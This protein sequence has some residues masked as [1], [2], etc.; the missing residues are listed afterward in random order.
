MKDWRKE[1]RRRLREIRRHVDPKYLPKTADPDKWTEYQKRRVREYHQAIHGRRGGWSKPGMRDQ[2]GYNAKEYRPR[3]KAAKKA[4]RQT[5]KGAA[6]GLQGIKTVWVPTE[7]PEA[8]SVQFRPRTQ[9]FE[10][11]HKG[12]HPIRQL[13]IRPTG[14]E[15]LEALKDPKGWAEK[16]VEQVSEAYPDMAQ[17][18]R[19]HTVS[20]TVGQSK[21]DFEAFGPEYD[22]SASSDQDQ[23]PD[24]FSEVSRS[25]NAAVWFSFVTVTLI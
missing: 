18:W 25:G 15:R 2:A 12:A 1:H 11:E 3:S 21:A 4:A 5:F 22:H 17:Y 9:S 6:K 24:V 20:G 8:M 10:L 16:K 14:K 13:V 7:H 23:F 19:I